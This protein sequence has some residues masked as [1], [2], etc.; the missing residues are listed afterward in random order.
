LEK[1]S[2]EPAR[3]RI[4][5]A[6]EGVQVNFCRNPACAQSGIPAG[7][8]TGRGQGTP[9]DRYV[10][11]GAGRGALCLKCSGCGEYPPL[12]SNQGI[13][14]ERARLGAYLAAFTEP[15]CP[16]EG[17]A[18]ATVG[19]SAGSPHYRRYGTSRAGS[20]RYRCSACGKTFSG[21]SATVGRKQ[22]HKNRLI[23]QLLMNKS[24][25]RHVCE[26]AGIAPGSLYPKVDFLHRQCL[27]FAGHRE[28]RLQAGFAVP[29]LYIGVDRQEY[30]VN[31]TRRTNLPPLNVLESPPLD[32]KESKE[33][34]DVR[35]LGPLRPSL[36][37]S[38]PAM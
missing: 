12:K 20:Q 33:P 11:V 9:K 2:S 7:E 32:R 6:A 18:Q 1:K 36:S 3:P 14:A 38:R 16:T 27:A 35:G 25:L 17:C 4:P 8:S 24:P 19:I 22:S 28:R 10:V 29:R 23:F 13:A 15:A 21:G 31:W 37:A 5:P 26:V 30:V 34:T